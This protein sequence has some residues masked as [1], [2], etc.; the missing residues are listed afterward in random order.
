MKLRIGLIL[1]AA[2]LLGTL[3]CEK[4]PNNRGNIKGSWKVASKTLEL[5]E[6]SNVE[7][8]N[9][10]DLCIEVGKNPAV[11]V[12]ADDN[13]LPYLVTRVA[14]GKLELMD[15]PGVHLDPRRRIKYYLTVADLEG[16]SAFGKGNVI[17]PDLE[18]ERFSIVS[19]PNGDFT[20]GTL[21][22]GEV[23]INPGGEGSSYCTN[24]SGL[25]IAAL[26]AKELKVRNNTNEN[27]RI[28]GG[29]VNRQDITINNDGNY[30]AG[31]VES[32][33]AEVHV[34]G[35]GSVTIRV[36]QSLNAYLGNYSGNVYYAGDPVIT[37]TRQSDSSGK[38][39]KIHE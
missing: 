38:L 13:L 39:I 31:K 6:F 27:V 34:N 16:I 9:S 26:Y 36:T 23:T 28:A 2:L 33:T 4:P 21:T 35:S 17:A 18:G 8:L 3:A 19:N 12:E 10:G 11:R 20:M 5:G 22:A 14:N 15:K 37:Q 25:K 30:E 1:P 7:V 29:K 32:A 24:P